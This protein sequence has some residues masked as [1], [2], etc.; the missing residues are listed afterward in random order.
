NIGAKSIRSWRNCPMVLPK[1][2]PGFIGHRCASISTPRLRANMHRPRH[3]STS[4]NQRGQPS[5]WL[6]HFSTWKGIPMQQDLLQGKSGEVRVLARFAK[7]DNEAGDAPDWS[8]PREVTL[9]IERREK[10][11]LR[12]KHRG[13]IAGDILTMNVRDF[14]WAEYGERDHDPGESV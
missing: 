10:N 13:Q 4:F 1:G 12:A 3:I 5:R 7:R 8:E 9:A 14:N 6:F 11:L 2:L